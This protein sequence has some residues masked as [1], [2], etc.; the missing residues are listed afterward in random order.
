[1]GVRQGGARQ[2]SLALLAGVL[3]LLH[4]APASADEPFQTAGGGLFFGYEFGERGGFEWGLEA[5]ATRFLD[6]KP[7]ADEVHGVG[8]LL[9][10]TAVKGSRLKLTL[11]AHGG[12]ELPELEYWAALDAELGA[13][14]HFE[15][16]QKPHLAVHTGVTVESLIF[17]LYVQPE[18]V[19]QK[20][21]F[22]LATSLGGG[23]RLYPTFVNAFHDCIVYGRPCR[24]GGGQPQVA[25]VRRQTA[26]DE[27]CPEAQLWARRVADESASV[28]AFLQLARELAQL[29]APAELV[30][31]ALRAAREEL[32]HTCE[33]ARLAAS[34][35]GAGVAP[36]LP[37]FRARPALPRPLALRRVVSESWLD[38]V[39][40]EGAAAAIA[41]A[42]AVE[43]HVAEEARISR[44]IAR[45]EA[46]HALLAFDVL[47]WALTQAP[48]LRRLLRAR[49]GTAAPPVGASSLGRARARELTHQSAAR[50]TRQL[51]EIVA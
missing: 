19:E 23:L 5:F 21:S 28:P 35:G 45:E 14:V 6:R 47:R 8:P 43:T 27:R 13:S 41:A 37:V 26:F 18:W 3:P 31:R 44:L 30:Q 2:L 15:T 24:S 50:A 42:E 12:G 4:T 16:G 32:G 1:M 22:A 17:H 29:G 49:A 39:L 20:G 10:F 40:N 25:R 38:G 34:F 46:G 51:R 36:A 9:R 33:A 48:E 11:A 7:C